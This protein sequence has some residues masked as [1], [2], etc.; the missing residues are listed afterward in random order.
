M[1]AMLEALDVRRG[2]RVLEIGT[3]TGYNAALVAQLTGDAERVTTIDIDPHLAQQAECALHATVGKVGVLVG[4]GTRI[5]GEERM[6]RIMVTASVT[7]IPRTWYHLLTVGG[8]VVMP[9]TGSLGSS[10][11]LI[12]TKDEGG[13]SGSFS[14]LPVAFMPM[15]EN[16]IVEWP[17]DDR[18]G[19]INDAPERG[20]VL[21]PSS[22]S[23]DFLL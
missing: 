6:D 20:Y 2:M 1:A 10:G 13:G 18:Y 8:R 23:H 12:L 4:D 14:P 3:G 17:F 21:P 9:L 16:G 11:L 7:S 19:V 15:H 5:Q 22:K